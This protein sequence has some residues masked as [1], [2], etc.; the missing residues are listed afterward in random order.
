VN[1]VDYLVPVDARIVAEGDVPSQTV[2]LTEMIAAVEGARKLKLLLIDACRDNPFD[3]QASI[4]SAPALV[5]SN[6]GP[7]GDVH[8]R[9]LSQSLG[10]ERGLAQIKT[11]SGTLVFFAAKEGQTTLDGDG[12]DSPF[13]VAVIQRLA[14]PGV[15]INKLLRLVR[16]DVMEATA[17]RQ[18]PAVYGS[19]PEQQNFYFVAA[20]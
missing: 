10:R 19:V 1:G 8:A 13:A 16:D 15:E 4:P 20:R 2:P 17:G 12:D 7:D 18:E 5:A 11:D 6:A 3:T 14:T 9:S